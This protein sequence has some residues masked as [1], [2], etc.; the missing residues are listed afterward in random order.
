[1]P[2]TGNILITGGS[3][4]LGHAIVRTAERESWDCSITIYSRSELRQAQM[5]GKYPHCRYVLGDV[6][7]YDRLAA[8]VAG[9]DLVI[10]GA[11]MKRIP[12]CEA[13]P[14]E[15]YATN[16]QGSISVARAC[17]VAGVKRCV[18]VSTDKAVRA[19]TCYGA[20]KLALETIFRAQPPGPTIFT[21]VRYG[22]V[23]A[24]NGSVVPL[25]R[26]QASEG[27]PLTITDR[28]C[29]RFWMAPSTAVELIVNAAQQDSGIVVPK[30]AAL[31]LVEMADIIAPGSDTTETGLRSCEKIHEDLIH[32]DEPVVDCGS[33]FMV[34]AWHDVTTH[35]AL[36]SRYTS[37]TAPRL[38]REAFLTMLE[39]AESYE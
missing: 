38:S 3:G 15:C 16:V 5:R 11:A 8:A 4:T 30:M 2:L 32:E 34:G 13:N 17:I 31:S 21:L 25:W 39:E 18:G 27:R 20:S 28:R 35:S 14:V 6:R 10:H 33:V 37:D 7:D 24:S 9:H 23:V 19:I 29:T 1:M 22:N 12:E 36:G 26:Q